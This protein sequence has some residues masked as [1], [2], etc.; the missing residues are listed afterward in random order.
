MVRFGAKKVETSPPFLFDQ[1]PVTL[2]LMH[3]IPY[4]QLFTEQ[5]VFQLIKETFI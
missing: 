5:G 3:Y 4:F 1:I 2:S